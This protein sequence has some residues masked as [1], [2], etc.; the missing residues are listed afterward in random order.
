MVLVAA[1]LAAPFARAEILNRIVLRVNDRIVTLVD[2]RERLSEQQRAIQRSKLAPEE[3]AKAMASA[4]ADALRDLMDQALLMARG[5]QMAIT[6]DESDIARAEQDARR[7][8]GI[9]SDEEFTEALAQSGMT[10]DQLRTQ[11]REQLVTRQVLS[12][13][14]H[15]AIKVSEEDMLRYYRD[16]PA[17]FTTAARYKLQEVVVLD[18]EGV[19]AADRDALAARIA[20]RLAGGETLAAIAAET[21]TTGATSNLI[22][23]G[24]VTSPD[25]DPALA[26][27]VADVE[28][29]RTSAA[30]PGRG[31][32]HILLVSEREPAKLRG[33]SEVKEELEYAERQ[34]RFQ[35]EFAKYM[36]KLERQAYVVADPPAEAAAFRRS[37]ETTEEL[38][39]FTAPL[40]PEP[41]KPASPPPA[42]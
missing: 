2:Y 25:L 16:H 11:L 24:W 28:P 26:T 36:L 22:D 14:V 5:D 10:R 42:N 9:D 27:G 18:R 41:E 15:Q 32:L 40:V 13:E 33:Y 4:P 39:A 1:G 35:G 34:R 38:P 20:Q 21:A 8:F 6:V 17:D 29:G 3:A 31:G 7:N 30:I 23:L 19:P 12:R 37:Q